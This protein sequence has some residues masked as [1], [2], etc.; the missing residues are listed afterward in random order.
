[1]KKISYKIKNLYI[2][3][4]IVKNALHEKKEIKNYCSIKIS[5]YLCAEIITER[6]GEGAERPARNG[7]NLVKFL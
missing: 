2:E 5:V 4:A 3:Y 1:M 7:R 6:T